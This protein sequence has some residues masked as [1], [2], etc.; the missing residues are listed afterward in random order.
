MAFCEAF[1]SCEA[2][3]VLFCAFFC[4]VFDSTGRRRNGKIRYVAF[5][6]LCEKNMSLMCMKFAF[7]WCYFCVG[8]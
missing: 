1:T 4:P 3:T 6:V 7:T 2:E 8:P 5:F